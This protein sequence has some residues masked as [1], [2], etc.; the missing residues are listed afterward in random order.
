[1]RQGW[2]AFDMFLKMKTSEFSFILFLINDKNYHEITISKEK[3]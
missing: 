2:V 3:V 1:M